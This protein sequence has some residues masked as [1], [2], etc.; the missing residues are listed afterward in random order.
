MRLAG[1]TDLDRST[2]LMDKQGQSFV[3]VVKRIQL[4]NVPLSIV[5]R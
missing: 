2:R 5:V 1:A 4:K 3:A